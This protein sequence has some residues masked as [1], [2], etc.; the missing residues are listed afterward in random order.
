MAKWAD[1]VIT[2]V[3]YDENQ[4]HIIKV[5]RRLDNGE[6]L[7]KEEERTRSQ[8][9]NAIENKGYTYVTSYK[10]NGEWYK[11]KNVSII[12]VDGKKYLRTDSNKT[13]QDNLGEL[14]EF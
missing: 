12:K 13:T 11:G 9:V 5:K 6:T 14:P 2:A 3:R 10:K 8:V 4:E 7:E 1:F